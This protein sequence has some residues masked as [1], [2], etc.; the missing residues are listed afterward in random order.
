MLGLALG[1]VPAFGGGVTVKSAPITLFTEFQQAPPAPVIDAIQEELESIMEP[2]GLHFDWYP[3]QEASHRVSVQLAVVHF[4]GACDTQDLRPEWGFPGPLGWTHVSDG[5]VLPFIDINC[6]GVRLFVQR[7]LIEFPVANRETAYG[8]AV[9]R[10]LAHELYHFLVNTK[11]H[12]GGGVAKST[13]S[14]GELLSETLR[15][16]KKECD[17]LR[18]RTKTGHTLIPAEGQ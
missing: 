18:A 5:E 16:G 15:F 9:A 8:R 13:Y 11:A 6:E 7:Q 2:V 4:K 14:V 10:V 12:P 17:A 3:L 1:V